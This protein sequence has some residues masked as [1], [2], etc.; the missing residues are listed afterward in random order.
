MAKSLTDLLKGENVE[1][2]YVARVKGRFPYEEIEV[3]MGLSC[4]SHKDGIYR[5]DAEGKP[6]KTK[7]FFNKYY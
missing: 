1:K 2:L 4:V 5:A 3:N 7:I 6:S